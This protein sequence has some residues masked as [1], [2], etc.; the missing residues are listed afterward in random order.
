MPDSSF[1]IGNQIATT[2]IDADSPITDALMTKYRS[3]DIE[4]IDRMNVFGAPGSVASGSDVPKQGTLTITANTTTGGMIYCDNYTVGSG[5]TV[6][7]DNF[8]MI[9]AT[10]TITINGTINADYQGA[11]I[12][13]GLFDNAVPGPDGNPGISPGGGG[14]SSNTAQSGGRGGDVIGVRLGGLGGDGPTFGNGQA[15][16]HNTVSSTYAIARA[17]DAGL[18]GGASGG[19]GAKGSGGGVAGDG[20]R[21]GGT[22]ILIAPAIILGAASILSV[23]GGN[24]VSTSDA[25]SGGGGGGGLI[26]VRCKSF[27]GTAGYSIIKTGGLTGTSGGGN[28]IG[29]NGADGIFQVDIYA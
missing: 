17:L 15:G 22:I 26:Y 12:R 10:G 5:V 8:F 4:L 28:Q 3:R 11:D 23:R 21:G 2:E 19:A 25:G 16:S 9:V 24:G 20:G 7:V 18:L 27:T 13:P 6:S 14:G 1:S 29:G